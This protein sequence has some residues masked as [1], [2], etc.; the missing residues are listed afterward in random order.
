[1]PFPDVESIRSPED[2]QEFVGR[3]KRFEELVREHALL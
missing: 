1:M 3:I 2:V